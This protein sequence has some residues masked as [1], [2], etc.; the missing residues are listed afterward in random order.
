MEFMIYDHWGQVVVG[1]G[2]VIE[3]PL[4]SDVTT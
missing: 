1:G 2:S 4:T 3:S